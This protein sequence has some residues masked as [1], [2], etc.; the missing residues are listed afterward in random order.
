MG[1][2]NE[3]GASHNTKISA[4]RLD[5]PAFSGK[6]TKQW[7]TKKEMAR[8]STLRVTG[9]SRGAKDLEERAPRGAGADME[10][11]IDKIREIFSS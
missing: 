6:L 7:A 4:F 9:A 1:R 3:A 5:S 8:I 10:D 11:W 2:V